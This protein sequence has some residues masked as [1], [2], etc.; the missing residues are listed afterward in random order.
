VTGC[1]CK[2]PGWC[3][4]HQCHKHA[5]WHQ[6]CQTNQAYFDAWE[7]RIGPGQGDPLN[8]TSKTRLKQCG[9]GC[10]LS[11][12]LAKFRIFSKDG[13]DCEKHAA[14][15]DKWGSDKCEAEMDTILA[16]MEMEAKERNLLFVRQAARILV[17][18]AIWKARREAK[19]VIT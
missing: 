4:R 13:C 12:L 15:M 18:T 10:H 16:W 5:R 1:Q 19:H 3:E 14:E 8:R 7:N 2:D 6:L 9:P 11:R 17:K